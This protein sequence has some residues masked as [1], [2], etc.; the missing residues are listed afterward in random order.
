[1]NYLAV[2]VPKEDNR[3]VDNFCGE[4]FILLIVREKIE[5]TLLIIITISH[6]AWKHVD[7]VFDLIKFNIRRFSLVSFFTNMLCVIAIFFVTVLI[8]CDNIFKC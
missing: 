4:D 1:M 6:K 5:K 2:I 3:I 8:S 7:C